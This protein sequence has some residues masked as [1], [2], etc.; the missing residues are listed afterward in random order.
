MPIRVLVLTCL[1]G[2]YFRKKPVLCR[3]DNFAKLTVVTGIPVP[4]ALP[5]CAPKLTPE[6]LKVCLP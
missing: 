3:S 6:R 5:D 4:F 1:Y 2:T